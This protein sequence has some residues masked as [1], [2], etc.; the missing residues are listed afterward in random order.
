MVF[1]D[2]AITQTSV[3]VCTDNVEKEVNDGIVSY[4]RELGYININVHEKTD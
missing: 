2:G 3:T 1:E 4:V